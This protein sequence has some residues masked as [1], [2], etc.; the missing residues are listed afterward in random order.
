MQV[1]AHTVGITVGLMGVAAGFELIIEYS[2]HEGLDR[3]IRPMR[4]LPFNYLAI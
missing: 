4:L 1:N 3:S 2:E